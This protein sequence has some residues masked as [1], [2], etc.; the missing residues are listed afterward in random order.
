MGLEP[1]NWWSVSAPQVLD[2]FQPTEDHPH[3]LWQDT[4][5]HS[6]DHASEYS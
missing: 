3:V 6:A 2:M 5:S 4:A 1:H